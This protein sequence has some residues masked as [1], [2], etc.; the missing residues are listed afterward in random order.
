M[1]SLGSIGPREPRL[2]EF[3]SARIGANLE[4]L[5]RVSQA[6]PY[7]SNGPV[8][9]TETV[10]LF[11][12]IADSGAVGRFQRGAK[13]KAIAALS[14]SGYVNEKGQLT[15]REKRSPRLG[16]TSNSVYPSR[17]SGKR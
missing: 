6:Q 1:E 14:A 9:R 12:S 17:P 5:S 11:E 2:D 3:A 4:D 13:K 7:R 16:A 10:Q 15:P 8:L